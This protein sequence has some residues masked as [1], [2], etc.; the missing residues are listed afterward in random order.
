[1]ARFDER[2]RAARG[3]ADAAGDAQPSPPGQPTPTGRP[4]AASFFKNVFMISFLCF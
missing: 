2:L 1:M 4:G 3:V